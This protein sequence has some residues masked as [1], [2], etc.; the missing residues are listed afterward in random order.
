LYGVHTAESVEFLGE[1]WDTISEIPIPV[2]ARVHMK[3]EL[4]EIEII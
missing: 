2:S 3:R 4:L 1:K